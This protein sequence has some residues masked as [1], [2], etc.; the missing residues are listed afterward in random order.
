MK[1]I[2]FLYLMMLALTAALYPKHVLSQTTG[3]LKFT[4]A[5]GAN[6]LNYPAGQP[7]YLRLTDSDRNL[8]PAAID[9]VNLL[10]ASQSETAGETIALTE[11]AANS[12][13]FNGSINT[14]AAAAVANDG[15]LQVTKGDKLTATWNDPAD[16]F[17]NPAVVTAFAYYDVTLLSGEINTHST[18]TKASSPYL[19]TGDVTVPENVSL[20]IQ[21]GVQVRIVPLSDDQNGGNDPNRSELIIKG[22]LIATGLPSDSIRFLSNSE[23]PA[24]G[25]W[26]GIRIQGSS[27]FCKLSFNTLQ[28]TSYSLYFSDF[29][30]APDTI[31]ITNNRFNQSGFGIRS[32]YYY[33]NFRIASNTFTNLSQF[34]VHIYYTS[35]HINIQNNIFDQIGSGIYIGFHPNL[36]IKNSIKNNTLNNVVDLGIRIY[37]ASFD[38]ISNNLIHHSAN[39]ISAENVTGNII[40]NDIQY[41]SNLGMHLLRSD[42]LAENN[43]IKYNG[44]GIH[45]STDFENPVT[46]T[47]R[48]NTITNNNYRGIYNESYAKTVANYNNIHDNGGYGQFDLENNSAFDI[49]ARYNFWGDFSTNQMQTGPNPKNISKIKD[50]YDDFNLGF[51]NY[52]QWSNTPIGAQSTEAEIL[53]FS[54]EGQLAPAS[55]NA[56][57]QIIEVMVN[58]QTAI[59]ALTAC[60]TISENAAISVAGVPQICNVSVNDYSNTVV[61]RVTAEDG[62]T[63]K[64]WTVNVQVLSNCEPGWTPLANL[65]FNMQL[66]GQILIDGEVSL[67]PHDV[68]GAFV[69]NECR[70]IASP[71]PEFDGLI[72]LTVSSNEQSGEQVELKIWNS[73]TCSE[74]NAIPGFEF[75]NQSEIGTFLEPYQVRCGAIQDVTFGQGYTWFSLNVN[76]GSMSPASLFTDLTPCYDD[77][78]IGQTSFALFTGSSWIGSLTNLGL[79]KMYRMK[80]CS[81]QNLSLMGEAAALNPISLNAGYTWL[82]Y[83]PQQCQSVSAAMAELTPGP[84]YDDRVIGQSSFALYTG[85]QWIGSLTQMCP[86]KGYVVKLANAQTLTYP[87]G[88]SKSSNDLSEEIISPTGVYPVEGLQHTMMVVGRL[89]LNDDSYS[90]N[91]T[92]VIYAFVGEECRGIAIPSNELNGLIFMSIGSNVESGEM[93]SFKVWLDAAQTLI[94]LNEVVSFEAMQSVGGLESPFIFTLSEMVGLE[95]KPDGVWIGE[96]YPNPFEGQTTIPYFLNE[97]TELSFSIYDS[98]GVQVKTEKSVASE[99]GRH[100]YIMESVGLPKGV[101][102]LETRYRTQHGFGIRMSKLVIK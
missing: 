68:V 28:H 85:S 76:P 7:I 18:W 11:T 60:W 72:F 34:A 71:N 1:K 77:R 98:R 9:Q 53:A 74:C 84:S 65:Q 43:I 45:V 63:Y 100:H 83:Q 37:Y 3:V 73:N 101:Y 75:V 44:Y 102:V 42:I 48:F 61:F 64:E 27:S 69:G 12:G 62:V 67:N 94:P 95:E 79:D 17:G 26:Y 89:Q 86:G 31:T 49:D 19:I 21:P 14:Q 32:Q 41:A 8:N 54:L 20:T 22:S 96:P 16:D 5:A 78:V 81:A 51:V 88:T 10:L 38:S 35:L 55:I 57:Q 99:K 33:Q 50:Q 92:D 39:G 87:V 58:P 91:P 56:A 82:G 29:N 70:G 23:N 47:L 46:D 30:G 90:A 97:A 13:I 4:D 93:V 36:S 59:A 40:G 52:G 25:D 80:L 6:T 24:V 2:Y 66:V 15:L